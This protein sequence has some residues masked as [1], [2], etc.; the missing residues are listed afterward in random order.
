[1]SGYTS[2]PGRYVPLG[3]LATVPSTIPVGGYTPTDSNGDT[4]VA[5]WIICRGTAGEFSGV[6]INEDGKETTFTDQDIATGQESTLGISN[7]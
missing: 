3:R 4:F 1:M 6:L 5:T 7:R 2:A